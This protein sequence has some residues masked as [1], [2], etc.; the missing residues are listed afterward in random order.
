MWSPARERT[1]MIIFCFWIG[2]AIGV[3]LLADCYGRGPIAWFLLAVLI[4][5][6]LAGV[7]LLIAGKTL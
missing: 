5:P 7:F 1:T 4:S 6:V 2:L 3:G